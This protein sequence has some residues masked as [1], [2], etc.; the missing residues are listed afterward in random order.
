MTHSSANSKRMA[1]SAIQAVAATTSAMSAVAS[2]LPGGERPTMA[3]DTA[4]S[5][6]LTGGAQ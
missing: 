6:T 3:S 2:A 4:S 1:T 5:M